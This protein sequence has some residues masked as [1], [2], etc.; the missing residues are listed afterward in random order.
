VF[1]K[2]PADLL[3]YTDAALGQPITTL[4]ESHFERVVKEAGVRKIKFHGLRHSAAT[5]LLQAGV[6]SHVVAA[7]LGHSVQILLSTYAHALPN[8]QADAAERLSD[9]LHGR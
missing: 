2:E 7:R 1:A 9:L 6:L 8:Q 3:A 4:S 5:L